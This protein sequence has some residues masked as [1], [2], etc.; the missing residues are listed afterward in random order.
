MALKTGPADIYVGLAL[1]TDPAWKYEY[2]PCGHLCR[3]GLKSTGP[4]WTYMSSIGP[5]WTSMSRIGPVW[6]SM[7][8]TFLRYDFSCS[9]PVFRSRVEC[10]QY[11]YKLLYLEYFTANISTIAHAIINSPAAF[12]I[13]F[14]RGIPQGRKRN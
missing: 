11:F 9:P 10:S 13:N 7:S 2:W 3:F 6:T 14:S 8:I 1:G 4:V 12:P 5:V